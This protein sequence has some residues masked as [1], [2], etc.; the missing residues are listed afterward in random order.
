MSFLNEIGSLTADLFFFL[1]ECHDIASCNDRCCQINFV[2]FSYWRVHETKKILKMYF[3]Y[4]SI[5]LLIFRL[6]KMK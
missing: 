6:I 2:C 5:F 1:G 4:G 3:M